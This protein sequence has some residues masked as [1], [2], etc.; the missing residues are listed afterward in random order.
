MRSGLNNIECSTSLK[1]IYYKATRPFQ[2]SNSC[3]TTV[4]LLYTSFVFLPTFE[5][6]R[7]FQDGLTGS[8]WGDWANYTDSPLR[9][10]LRSPG[11]NTLP[12]W[13]KPKNGGSPRCSVAVAAF[14]AS[15]LFQNLSFCC[16]AAWFGRYITMLDML[17]Q[18]FGQAQQCSGFEGL[19]GDQAPLG[20]WDPLGLSK[21]KDVEVFK[22]QET[23]KIFQATDCHG[24]QT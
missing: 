12:E 20:F 21:D 3:L 2:Q 11:Y 22:R 24:G 17:I 10:G 1:A 18:F 19:V 5:M 15:L 6:L 8:A 16:D 13:E 7:F 9:S 14:A 4:G 23:F